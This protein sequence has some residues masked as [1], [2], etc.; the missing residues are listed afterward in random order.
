MP[1]RTKCPSAERT[2]SVIEIKSYTKNE[3]DDPRRLGTCEPLKLRP[4]LRT[5]TYNPL[6]AES[7]ETKG[8]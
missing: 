8:R 1:D 7:S 5:I 4:L 2:T 3:F 6:P